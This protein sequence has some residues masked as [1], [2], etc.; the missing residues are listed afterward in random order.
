MI[1]KVTEDAAALE[2]VTR[3][4]SA[5]LAGEE[6]MSNNTLRGRCLE[7]GEEKATEELK[8]AHTTTTPPS[9]HSHVEERGRLWRL[10]IPNLLSSSTEQSCAATKQ[11]EQKEAFP[12]LG[13]GPLSNT[14]A[15]SLQRDMTASS[16]T[17]LPVSEEH[18]LV[19]ARD[20][21][22]ETLQSLSS[23]A[24]PQV[25]RTPASM[26]IDHGDSSNSLDPD[27]VPNPREVTL[28][29]EE[30]I[31]PQQAEADELY[32]VS[33]SI[34]QRVSRACYVVE[35]SPHAPDELPMWD[36]AQPLHT[37][38]DGAQTYRLNDVVR[39]DIDNDDRTL[40]SVPSAYALV[41][42]MRDVG[43][44]VRDVDQ[45]TFVLVAWFNTRHDA[46]RYPQ[47]WG[48]KNMSAWPKRKSHI[49][50]TRLQVLE[51]GVLRGV[52]DSKVKGRLETD[53]VHDVLRDGRIKKMNRDTSW[54]FEEVQ[55]SERT[56]YDEDYNASEER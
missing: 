11:N 6:D 2:E 47:D 24:E 48:C 31:Q 36:D 34:N 49:L 53:C 51:L 17:I 7:K 44:G 23:C 20:H 16:G 37:V 28:K 40:K 13:P 38:E 1:L 5:N 4:P 18:V 14:H 25:Q 3:P 56:L 15:L 46:R 39:V 12:V 9:A 8:D 22:N 30:R 41:V 27:R 42:A 21:R 32:V 33:Y 29:N 10:A 52:L 45:R 43:P 55:I 54:R 26:E 35:K 50:T 19:E